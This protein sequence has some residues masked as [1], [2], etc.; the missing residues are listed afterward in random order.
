VGTFYKK[1][2]GDNKMEIICE[3]GRSIDEHGYFP[4]DWEKIGCSLNPETI[5]ARYFALEFMK[6]RNELQKRL[7]DI[8]N[9]SIEFL[10]NEFALT[11]KPGGILGLWVEGFRQMFVD[12]GATNYLE[13][14]LESAFSDPD[15][16]KFL[17][18]I[19]NYP[20]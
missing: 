6:E 14:Y 16:I 1:P 17:F 3:C 10:R 2:I 19:Q 20:G 8:T 7:D 18:T 9:P 5:E 11:Q 13:I 4:E 12:Q 15:P